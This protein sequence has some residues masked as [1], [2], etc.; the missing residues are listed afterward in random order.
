MH[1]ASPQEGEAF[2]AQRWPEARAVSDPQHDLYRAFGLERGTAK[3]LFSPS[4]WVSGM[5]TLLKGHMVGLPKGDPTM[6][7]GWFLVSGQQVV[8]SH[9]HETAG[10]ERRWAELGQAWQAQLA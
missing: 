7:S 1:L 9:V 6:M 10:A 4:N 3:Q 2:F 8:W 5:K